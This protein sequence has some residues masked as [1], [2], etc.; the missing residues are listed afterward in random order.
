[1]FTS[2]QSAPPANRRN[3]MIDLTREEIGKLYQMLDN[4]TVHG[5][6]AKQE[7]VDLMIKLVVMDA[8]LTKKDKKTSA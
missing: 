2:A 3:N 1:M 7:I 4:V 6:V 5:E 8:E